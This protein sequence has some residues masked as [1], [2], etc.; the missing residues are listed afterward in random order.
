MHKRGLKVLDLINVPE[1]NGGHSAYDL[2]WHNGEMKKTLESLGG[3]V[4]KPMPK[5]TGKRG[6]AGAEV[7]TKMIP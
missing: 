4:V 2:S 6:K 1:K 3:K 5:Q 7:S